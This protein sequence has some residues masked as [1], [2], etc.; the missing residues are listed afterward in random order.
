MIKIRRSCVV[1]LELTICPHDR[2]AAA[3]RN[4]NQSTPEIGANKHFVY[5]WH[6]ICFLRGNSYV[7]DGNDD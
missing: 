7:Y 1:A 4:T 3:A 6:H 2:L 5:D